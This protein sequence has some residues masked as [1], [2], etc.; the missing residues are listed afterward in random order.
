MFDGMVFL[1]ESIPFQKDS[2][3]S[4]VHTQHPCV[5]VCMRACVRACMRACVCVCEEV[6]IIII[7]TVDRYTH[8]T[9][10]QR[11]MYTYIDCTD[12]DIG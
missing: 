8:N 6:K 1:C 10:Q 2:V 5:C 3:S 11:L 4:P 12:A 9:S 7:Q